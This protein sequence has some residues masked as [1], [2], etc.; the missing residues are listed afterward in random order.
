MVRV[1]RLRGPLT[2]LLVVVATSCGLLGCKPGWSADGK[3]VAFWYSPGDEET[4]F[5]ATYD[6]DTGAVRR[7]FV[8]EQYALLRPTYA[9]DGQSLLLLA[10]R[11]V[12]GAPGQP[13]GSN[14]CDIDVLRIRLDPKATT[15]APSAE[16]LATIKQ[17]DGDALVLTEMIFDGENRLWWTSYEKADKKAGRPERFVPLRVDLATGKVTRPFQ[18]RSIRLFTGPAGIFG[19][20]G[21]VADWHVGSMHLTK[22]GLVFEHLVGALGKLGDGELAAIGRTHLAAWHKIAAPSGELSHVEVLIG[23]LTGKITAHIQAPEAVTDLQAAAF[24]QEDRTLWAFSQGHRWLLRF[25]ASAGTF[26]G[27]TPVPE[28]DRPEA[29]AASPLGTHFAGSFSEPSE[30]GSIL[31]VFDVTGKQAEIQRVKLPR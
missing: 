31:R 13:R 1:Q 17:T 4:S 8:S 22:E 27:A 19:V 16:K 9:P 21:R 12:E 6:L 11:E 2:L 24:S 25:D 28:G 29:A 15:Q 30:D 23:D 26:S 10:A 3:Q 20:E 18:D 5:L 14:I 7:V